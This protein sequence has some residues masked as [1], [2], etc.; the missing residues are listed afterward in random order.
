MQST[1]QSRRPP[2]TN[3]FKP[4]VSGNPFGKLS[5]TAQRAL[6]QA[7]SYELAQELGGFD[8]LSAIEKTLIERAAELTLSKPR[9]HDHRLRTANVVNRI[10]RDILARR[11]SPGGNAKPRRSPL[12]EYL[13]GRVP[14]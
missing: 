9:R 12:G 5:R 8:T 3:G 1:E 13:K 7:R 4:G 11:R 2:P 14:A 6:V 10:L